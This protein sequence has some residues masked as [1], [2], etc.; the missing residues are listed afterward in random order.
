MATRTSGFI[1]KEIRAGGQ[2]PTIT[3][4]EETIFLENSNTGANLGLGNIGSNVDC[5][6]G[7]PCVNFHSPTLLDFANGNAVIT[8]HDGGVFHELD[9]TVPGYTFGDILFTVQFSGGT[10]PDLG[11]QVFTDD[12]IT[13]AIAISVDPTI[14]KTNGGND[15]LITTPA[16]E[17]STSTTPSITK[18][19]LLSL[20][21]DL[22]TEGFDQTKQWKIS[23]VVRSPG[24]APLPGAFWL[25]GSVLAGSAGIAGYR[26][27]RRQK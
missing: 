7:N 4:T 27:R 8:A 1:S 22:S 12:L 26:R 16:A 19:L 2:L 23:N 21:G 3:D 17:V 20:Y 13:P 15:F 9:V 5:S 11:I 14:L 18:I 10:D 25:F 24:E 6:V